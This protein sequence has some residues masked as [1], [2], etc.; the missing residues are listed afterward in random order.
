MLS[1]RAAMEE[2]GGEVVVVVVGGDGRGGERS[3]WV[4]AVGMRGGGTQRDGWLCQAG[5]GP[6]KGLWH[7]ESVRVCVC[8]C[9]VG[10]GY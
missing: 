7:V 3:G 1:G 4:G 6:W 9:V 5:A 2:D 8:A 10:E